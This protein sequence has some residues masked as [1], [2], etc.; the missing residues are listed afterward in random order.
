[1][2]EL[3]P[4]PFC[5]GS[6]FTENLTELTKYGEMEELDDCYVTCRSCGCCGKVMESL[7]QAVEVWNRRPPAI[8]RD[9]TQWACQCGAS[10]NGRQN[11][12][13]EC[14]GTLTKG[15]KDC[16]GHCNCQQRGQ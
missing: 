8:D 3:K 16:H 6:A 11:Y 9:I 1:M 14:G 12:C 2:S 7:E 13:P 5:G 10:V 4:C 15:D